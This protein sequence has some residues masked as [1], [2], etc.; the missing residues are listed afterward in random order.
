MHTNTQTTTGAKIY[1]VIYLILLILMQDFLLLRNCYYKFKGALQF[2]MKRA[3]SLC[4][5]VKIQDDAHHQSIFG[6]HKRSQN[7]D[8]KYY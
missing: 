4:A 7:E 2:L 5:S 8:I 1:I 3:R 6:T